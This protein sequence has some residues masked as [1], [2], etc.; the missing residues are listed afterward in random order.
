MLVPPL[1]T[2]RILQRAVKNAQANKRSSSEYE[3]DKSDIKFSKLSLFSHSRDYST[4]TSPSP[5]QLTPEI[6]SPSPILTPKLKVN[7][8][9]SKKQDGDDDTVVTLPALNEASEKQK[10][11]KQ[12]NKLKEME[13]KIEPPKEEENKHE[14]MKQ[15]DEGVSFP[16]I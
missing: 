1:K 9:K 7:E 15:E 6:I 10:K 12:S 2:L 11:K 3:H 16:S 13:I 4:G 5:A 8:A 14:E